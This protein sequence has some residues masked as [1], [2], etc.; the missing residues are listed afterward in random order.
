MITIGQSTRTAKT[1]IIICALNHL[2]DLTVPCINALLR[3]TQQPFELILIDDGSKDGTFDYFRSL[4]RKA[5][6]NQRPSGATRARNIG[7]KA[8]QGDY[9]AILDND[10]TVP[11]GWL[12]VLIQESG[13]QRVGIIGPVLTNEMSNMSLPRSDDG[14]MTVSA[15]AFA[16]ALIKREV[17]NQIGLLDERLIN[18]GED[19]DFCFRAVKAGYRVAITPRLIVPHKSFATR[20]DVSRAQIDR[21]MEIFKKKYPGYG[22]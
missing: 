4:T 19:T 8:S 17:L 5:Y 15:I 16:C 3:N 22:K 18:L 7:L 12:G 21:S 2:Q 20:K 14:L 13:K 1:S 6:R 11:P 9:I 10:V